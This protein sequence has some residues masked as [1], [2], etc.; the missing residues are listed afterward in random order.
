[1]YCKSI[2]GQDIAGKYDPDLDDINSL[3]MRICEYMDDHGECDF[4]FG[5]FGQQSWPVDV[6]TDLPV[7][8]E[9]LP[10]VLSLLSQ[11]ENFEIDFYEQ[12]IERTITCSY[13]PEKNAWIS[14][15][16]SQTEWQPNPSEEV[17]KTEDLFTSLNTAYF[18]FLESIL[19]LK[20]SEW[21]KEITQ[22][23]NAG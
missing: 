7:F 18:V 10:I 20:N 1:M 16:V 14:T 13:L 21:G 6:R 23:Q 17:I 5:G 22:W 3:L 12:G 8:L 2:Y 19:P 9:Q 11:H 15:C 4:E